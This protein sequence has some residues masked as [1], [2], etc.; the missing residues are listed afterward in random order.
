M[1]TNNIRFLKFKFVVISVILDR[2]LFIKWKA[3]RFL[4]K[5]SKIN[6]ILEPNQF[7]FIK[8]DL[9]PRR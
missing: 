4:T 9:L 2:Q 6:P 8:N 7:N 3:V 5:V 1:K